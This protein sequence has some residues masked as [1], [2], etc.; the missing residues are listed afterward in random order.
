MLDDTR[1]TYLLAGLAVCFL[2][3]GVL[4]SQQFDHQ[5]TQSFVGFLV[6]SAG[7][8]VIIGLEW[9]FRSA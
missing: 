4:A 8:F 7:A 1:R 2:G 6:A 3:G 5:V 9:R